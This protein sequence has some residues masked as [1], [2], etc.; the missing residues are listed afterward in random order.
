MKKKA[1]GAKR[2]KD[3]SGKMEKKQISIRIDVNTIEYFKNLAKTTGIAYQN[4]MN[5]YLVECASTNKKL[6]MNWG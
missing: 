5:Q 4:L 2:V 3:S 1:A 6:K